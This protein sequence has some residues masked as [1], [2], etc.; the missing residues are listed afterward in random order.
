MESLYSSLFTSLVTVLLSSSYG[1]LLLPAVVVVVV[2]VVIV[3]LSSSFSCLLSAGQRFLFSTGANAV[4]T[5][6]HLRQHGLVPCWMTWI[7]ILE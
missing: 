2:V 1:G 3:L 7:P 5:E 6:V 4:Y